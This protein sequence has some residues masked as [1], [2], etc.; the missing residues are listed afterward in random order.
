MSVQC[1][2]Q[3]A[4]FLQT[5]R[6]EPQGL[7]QAVAVVADS[8]HQDI[9]NVVDVFRYHAFLVQV[10]V[11][12]HA[13]CKQVV[14]D[15]IDDGAVHFTRHVHVERTGTCN[16]MC[17][18]QS[19]LL[20][21]NGAAHGGGHIVHYQH[22]LCRVGVQLFFKGQHDVGRH[23]RMVVARDTQIGVGLLH[24]EVGEEG[25]FQCRIVLRAGIYYA[26]T[27]VLTGFACGI[28][29]TAQGGYFHKI[30]ACARYNRYFHES[31]LLNLSQKYVF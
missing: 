28:D 30:G 25:G 18:L 9:A 17:H 4:A 5:E 12:G 26:V 20:G 6:R 2:Q 22:C 10:A 19:A 15:G 11:G 16:D 13:G 8:V 3:V 1:E 7:E 14:G 31:N 29:G 21:Y 24:G 23:L 27:D